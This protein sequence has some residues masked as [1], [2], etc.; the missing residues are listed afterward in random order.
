MQAII[1]IISKAYVKKFAFVPFHVA[2][3]NF[4]NLCA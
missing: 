1:A 2:K 3:I 4:Q